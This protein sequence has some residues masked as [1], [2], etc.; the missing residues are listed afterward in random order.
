MSVTSVISQLNRLAPAQGMWG[1]HL[2]M[3][4]GSSIA[5]IVSSGIWDGAQQLT[6]ELD[7]EQQE[8]TE[9]QNPL[10][11]KGGDK[12]REFT[13]NVQVTTLGTG[14]NPIVVYNSWHRDLGKS[15]YFFNGALPIDT[16]QYIL[17]TVEL[18]FTYLDTAADG[19]PLRADISLTFVEDAILAVISKEEKEEKKDPSKATKKKSPKAQ[20][21]IDAAKILRETKKSYGLD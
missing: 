10:D 16:S 19:T 3:P 17:Q 2:L 18:H 8:T 9:A 14:Q 20:E 6:A 5:G 12:S 13:I 15:Y 1:K 21:K 11:V 7:V 4:A